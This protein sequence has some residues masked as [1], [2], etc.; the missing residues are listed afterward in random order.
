MEIEI[1]VEK[2]L[3]RVTASLDAFAKQI[4]F[5]TT[6]ALNMLGKRV[7]VAERAEIKKEFPTAT[8]FT[9]GAVGLLKARKDSLQS[10][11]FVRDIAA[12]YLLPYLEGGRHFLNSRALL[13][14]KNVPLNQYGNLSKNRLATLKA[15][16]DVFIGAVKTKHGTINGVWQRV[17][18]VTARNA[19]KTRKA[20]VAK[21]AHLKLLI[22][23][24]D[25]LPVKQHLAWGSTAA[26]IVAANFDKDFGKAMAMAIA[27]AKLK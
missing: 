19:T 1:D 26:K 5:A 21:A 22:R 9:I 6:T 17:A 7:Q 12:A 16:S 23:F 8:P 2:D 4:P 11:I 27:T 20:R 15:R 24:G 25:A 3:R 10:I 14:P 13:N 18:A